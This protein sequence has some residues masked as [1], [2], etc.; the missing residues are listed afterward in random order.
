MMSTSDAVLVIYHLDLQHFHWLHHIH[1]FHHSRRKTLQHPEAGTQ[2][3]AVWMRHVLAWTTT[4]GYP[5][6]FPC[7]KHASCKIST[8]AAVRSTAH[9]IRPGSFLPPFASVSPLSGK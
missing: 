8:L 4:N 5:S 7:P 3:Q 2:S 1:H 9:T 6:A